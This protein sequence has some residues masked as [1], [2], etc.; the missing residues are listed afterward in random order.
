MSPRSTRT[1]K[2]RAF[3]L[4]QDAI[5]REG[6]IPA[7]CEHIPPNTLCVTEG[8]WR[9][10]CASGCLSDGATDPDKK[11]AAERMAFKRAAEKL[12]GTKVGKWDL[13]VWIVR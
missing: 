10:Y 3:E 2:D 5:A 13:W 9:R 6:T 1:A 8:L 12:I 11:A 7:A 4:L